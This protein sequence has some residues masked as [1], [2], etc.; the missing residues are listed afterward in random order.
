MTSALSAFPEEC[1]LG[2]NFVF[3]SLEELDVEQ[4]GRPALF[5]LISI[6]IIVAMGTVVFLLLRARS[7]RGPASK[8]TSTGR[9][10][11]LGREAG[12]A[13]SGYGEY[14][15]R[16]LEGEEDDQEEEEEDDI[17]Y[18]GRDGM[19]YRKFKYG[20]LDEDE[21]LEYDEESYTFT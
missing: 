6:F 3:G 12:G 17:V 11:K 18:M 2:V 8:A 13:D 16:I 20:L 1:I 15:D 10:E 7:K 21:E 19:V 5:A 9:Y 4:G 14:S